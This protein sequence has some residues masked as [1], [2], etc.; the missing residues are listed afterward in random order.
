MKYRIQPWYEVGA[1]MT[2]GIANF[3]GQTY[4]K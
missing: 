4:V 1:S 2:F 3:A